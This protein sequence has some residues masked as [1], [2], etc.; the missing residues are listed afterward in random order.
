MLYVCILFFSLTITVTVQF[1][2]YEIRITGIWS[3]VSIQIRSCSHQAHRLEAGIAQV[4]N[5]HRRSGWAKLVRTHLYMGRPHRAPELLCLFRLT[6]YGACS[7]EV[8]EVS[9]LTMAR[10]S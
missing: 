9:Q 6:W 10:F 8:Q 2:S 7:P 3:H 4:K 1:S 5:S